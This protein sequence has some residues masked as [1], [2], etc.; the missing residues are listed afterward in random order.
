[1]SNILYGNFISLSDSTLG[2]KPAE[3]EIIIS[4]AFYS[5]VE[6]NLYK[7]DTLK[8]YP[9]RIDCIMDTLRKKNAI[10]E[11]STDDM[12]EKFKILETTYSS[13]TVAFENARGFMDD[14]TPIV[15]NANYSCLIPG[16]VSVIIL[17]S[18]LLAI[19]SLVVCTNKNNP[20]PSEA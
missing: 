5:F 20:L 7:D 13:V 3:K 6:Y 12:N 19:I 16:M 9:R 15:E 14:I 2:L 8:K 4:T 10:T 17:A 18:I 1:M 11:I